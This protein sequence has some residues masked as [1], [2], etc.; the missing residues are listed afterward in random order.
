[1]TPQKLEKIK[2]TAELYLAH[3]KLDCPARMDIIEILAPED[4]RDSPK[5]I[6]HIENVYAEIKP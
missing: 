1:V 5:E 4:L 3:Y 6:N 2:R